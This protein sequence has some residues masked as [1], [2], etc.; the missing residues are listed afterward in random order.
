MQL[1]R[2]GKMESYLRNSRPTFV[3]EQDG[4]FLCLS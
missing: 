4:Y 3:R 2:P 1:T